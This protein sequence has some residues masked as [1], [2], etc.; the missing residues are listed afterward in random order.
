MAFFHVPAPTTCARLARADLNE[1][2]ASSIPSSTRANQAWIE[3]RPPERSRLV[4][5]EVG[6]MTPKRSRG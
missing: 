2:S 1:M 3:R 4:L 5:M 6:M